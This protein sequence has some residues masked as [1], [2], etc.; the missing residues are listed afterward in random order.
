MYSGK[1]SSIVNESVVSCTPNS[2]ATRRNRSIASGSPTKRAVLFLFLTGLVG[3]F[4]VGANIGNLRK[5]NFAVPLLPHRNVGGLS[6]LNV[7]VV[8]PVR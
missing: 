8:A 5:M 7:A 2:A 4:F 6:L 1:A 3:R